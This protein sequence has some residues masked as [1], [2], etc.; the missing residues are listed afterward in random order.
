MALAGPIA[1]AGACRGTGLG[2]TQLSAAQAQSAIVC[3]MNQHRRHF[4]ATKLHGNWLL[5]QAATEHSSSMNQ[6][7]YFSHN[8]SSDGDP[9]SR[10]S[11]TGYLSGASSWGVGEN[12]V[13]GTGSQATPQRAVAS[14]MASAEHRTIMLSRNFHQ[15]GIGFVAGSP[16]GGD[17]ANSAIY[18]A[19]FGYRH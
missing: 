5:A 13:W 1:S 17:E 14:W 18:T 2:P 4:H 16:T 3:L 8:S 19:D 6:L 7:D 9:V 11:N 15:V 12:L 10:I